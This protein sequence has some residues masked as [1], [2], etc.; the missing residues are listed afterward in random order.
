MDNPPGHPGQKH[1]KH[2]RHHHKKHGEDEEVEEHDPARLEANIVEEEISKISKTYE[3]QEGIT[4]YLFNLQLYFP[5][6]YV[7]LLRNKHLLPVHDWAYV[8]QIK[9]QI[10]DGLKC[11]ICLQDYYEMVVPHMAFCGHVYCLPCI[12]RHMMNSSLV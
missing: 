5:P 8:M 9:Y 12:M 6:P 10:F 1:K 11:P 4:D 3:D 7:E 2:N